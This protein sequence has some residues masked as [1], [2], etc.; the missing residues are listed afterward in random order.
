[1]SVIQGIMA[2]ARTCAN[3]QRTSPSL[4]S[5]P[6]CPSASAF[7]LNTDLLF[8]GLWWTYSHPNTWNGT[9]YGMPLVVLLV[10]RHVL[11]VVSTAAGCRGSELKI[12][13]ILWHPPKTVRNFTYR[14]SSHIRLGLGTPSSRDSPCYF[15][16]PPSSLY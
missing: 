3:T 13:E 14:A 12:K 8:E 10:H 6:S 15:C 9:Q 16:N 5:S 4:Q 11:S 7:L 1:M 2:E